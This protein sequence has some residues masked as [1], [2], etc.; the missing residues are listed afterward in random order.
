MLLEMKVAISCNDNEENCGS[1]GSLEWAPLIETH[2]G[3]QT[4]LPNVFFAM[5]AAKTRTKNQIQESFATTRRVSA[6]QMEGQI[7]I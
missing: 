3:H 2:G 6:R 1:N 4:S 5:E 7:R